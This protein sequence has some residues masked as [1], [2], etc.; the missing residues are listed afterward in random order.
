MNY[1]GMIVH[2]FGNQ[3]QSYLKICICAWKRL[4]LQ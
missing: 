3:V 1:S 4:L 2:A